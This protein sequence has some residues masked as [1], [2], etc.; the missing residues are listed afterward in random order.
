MHGLRKWLRWRRRLPDIRWARERKGAEGIGYYWA[1][2]VAS[3]ERKPACLRRLMRCRRQYDR[4]VQLE[5]GLS[6]WSTATMPEAVAREA[7]FRLA[8]LGVN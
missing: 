6:P 5:R 2:L 8:K 4:L 3:K 1:Y 7:N